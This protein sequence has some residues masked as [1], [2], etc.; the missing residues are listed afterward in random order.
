MSDNVCDK[1]Y[2]SINPVKIQCRCCVVFVL[3]KLKYLL[4]SLASF[5]CNEMIW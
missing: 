3:V 1:N 4:L 2:L 5:K